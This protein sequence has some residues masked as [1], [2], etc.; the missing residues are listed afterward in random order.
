MRCFL[1]SFLLGDERNAMPCNSCYVTLTNWNELVLRR[2]DC[3]G[4]ID[5]EIM[6]SLE[7]CEQSIKMDKFTPYDR[8]KSLTFRDKTNQWCKE[9]LQT[10]ILCARFRLLLSKDVTYYIAKL[11]WR[12]YRHLWMM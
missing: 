12:E 5:Y 3:E 6:P 2:K 7:K 9:A 10:W 11:I 8:G 4:R 1:G